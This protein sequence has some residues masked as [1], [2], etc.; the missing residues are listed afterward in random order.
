[1]S[2]SVTKAWIVAVE[3]ER[4]RMIP[5][6]SF[7]RPGDLQFFVTD[8]DITVPI[9]PRTRRCQPHPQPRRSDTSKG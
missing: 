7:I 3:T 8:L 1:M 6:F 5:R 4:N 9:S 2:K